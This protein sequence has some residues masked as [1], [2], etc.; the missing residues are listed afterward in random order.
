M[1]RIRTKEIN[2]P[3]QTNK[4]GERVPLFILAIK[5]TCKPFKIAKN[6]ERNSNTLEIIVS[7]F[8]SK[9]NKSKL[10]LD[11]MS[12]PIEFNRIH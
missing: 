11:T 5:N 4:N 8:Q 6:R 7:K 2:F 9:T 1:Y 3:D 12:A 10:R